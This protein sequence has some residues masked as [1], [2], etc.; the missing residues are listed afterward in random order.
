MNYVPMVDILEQ[1]AVETGEALLSQSV[2]VME[3]KS[4]NDLLTENDLWSENRIIGRL[5]Q[6][7]PN[8]NIISEE[9]NP[10]S[11]LEGM[12][13]VVD[14]IDG[15]CNYAA[16]ID[17]YGIQMALFDQ[18]TC[19]GAVIYFPA[20]G[21]T[22]RA[23][24]GGGAWKN[25]SRLL[26]NRDIPDS[27]GILLI[28]DYYDNIHIPM[29]TQFDLVKSLQGKFLKTRHFG[30]ACVDFVMLAESKAQAYI[31]Y[32]HKIWDIAPG[33]LIATEAGCRYSMVD[34]SSFEYGKPGLVVRSNM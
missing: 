5:R 23:V 33:L 7:W 13:V 28:S 3:H 31:T 1:I 25:G 30:A 17:M 20:N 6:T 22:Y 18:Q 2:K 16:G 34:G 29:D 4:R 14:P 32:Y 15:T 27:D 24:K 10:D 21:D 8:I 26:V 12:T 9:N 11:P 19:V